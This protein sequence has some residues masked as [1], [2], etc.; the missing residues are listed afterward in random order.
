MA[1][2][3]GTNSATAET[4]PT[5]V[6]HDVGLLLRK[7]YINPSE[8]TSLAKELT[9]ELMPVPFAP[10]CSRDIQQRFVALKAAQD[11]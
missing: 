2:L 6:A 1:K 7:Q 9:V 4:H 8:H 3:Q 10:L 11:I 5:A